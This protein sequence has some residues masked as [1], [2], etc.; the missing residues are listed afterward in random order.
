MKCPKCQTENPETRKCCSECG[1]KLLVICPQYGFE[2][3]P[4]DKF[5]GECG[6]DFTLST[7]PLSK[8]LAFDEK[9]AKIQKY[10]PGG[11]T[12]K[13]LARKNQD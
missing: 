9:L 12:E 2:N 8:D 11:L 13:M 10:L 3:L 1:A 7:K 4:K 5:C 6:N